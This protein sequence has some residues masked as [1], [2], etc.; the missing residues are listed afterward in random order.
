MK[1]MKNKKP[2]NIRIPDDIKISIVYFYYIYNKHAKI[3][4]CNDPGHKHLIIPLTKHFPGAKSFHLWFDTLMRITAFIKTA[5]INDPR[6]SLVYNPKTMMIDA[7]SLP[8]EIW[9]KAPKWK[10][11]LDRK[12]MNNLSNEWY[13]LKD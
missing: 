13:S 6:F 8:P 1:T 12:A 5:R 2:V 7:I 9:N 4:E 3:M 11:Y 10:K